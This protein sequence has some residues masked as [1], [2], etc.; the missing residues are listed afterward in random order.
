MENK[1]S[2]L[3]VTTNYSQRKP[4]NTRF[5]NNR[6]RS[7]QGFTNKSGPRKSPVVCQICDKPG[8]TAKTCF[9]LQ[10]HPAAN[11]ATS[12]TPSN[13]KWLLDSATSHN[14][15]SD[16]ANLYIHSEYE[17][18]DEVVLGD[19]TSL[20][21]AHIGSTTLPS[22]SHTLTLKETLH[23]PLI[24]KNLISVHKFTLDNNVIIEFHPFFYLVKDRRTGA[25]LM[26]GRCENGVYP[27]AFP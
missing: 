19:G 12:T 9:K 13:G 6:S 15:T 10:S 22:P 18:Q 14:I 23:L 25:M 1:A 11:C 24:H 8:N 27:V 3:V 26:R 20:K 2:A 21:I 16:L 4:S 7:K 5:Q 17:G